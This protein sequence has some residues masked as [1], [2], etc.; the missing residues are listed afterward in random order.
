MKTIAILLQIACLFLIFGCGHEAERFAFQPKF[1]APAEEITVTYD[2]SGTLLDSTESI[3][4]LAYC[5]PEG[6]PYVEEV[7]MKKNGKNWKGAFQTADTTLVVYVIFRSDEFLDDNY[8]EGY[9]ITLSTP[10][11]KPIKGAMARHA[12]VVSEGGIGPLRLKRD[13]EKKLNYLEKEFELYPEQKEKEDLIFQYWSV[14]SYFQNELAP[15]LMRD[16]LE[17]LEREED[18]NLRDLSMLAYWYEELDDEVKAGKYEK[19]LLEMK[20]IE[21]MSE[22]ERYAECAREASIYKKL[23]LIQTFSSDFPDSEHISRLHYSVISEFIENKQFQEGLDYLHNYMLDPDPDVMN[24]LAWAMIRRD[25]MLDTAVNLSKEA[26]AIVRAQQELEKM[27]AH[28]T[29]R[30]W[31]ER[32]NLILSEYLDTYGLGLCKLGKIEESVFVF[33]EA[34]EKNQHKSAAIRERYSQ[35]LVELGEIEKA[36]DIMR[37]VVWDYPARQKARAFYTKLYEEQTGS[38]EGLESFFTKVE[39]HDRLRKEAEIRTQMI[40]KKAPQF[41]LRDLDGNKVSLADYKGK[42]VILDFW[43]T[44]CGMCLKSFPDMQRTVNKYKDDNQVKFLFVDTLEKIE[45]PENRVREIIDKNNYTFHILLDED[46][47]VAG[48][49]KITSAPYEVIIGP[50]G[51]ICFEIKGYGGEHVEKLDMM[52]AMLR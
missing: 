2:P 23:Q 43:G 22:Y 20:Q 35:A 26:V 3:K 50:K 51:N 8:K 15:R 31:Q 12:G 21:G 38:T 47:A 33:A 27:P 19:Q 41:T 6:M 28:Y 40:N 4:M 42:I 49:Y 52:I 11:R 36:N 13:F 48:A 24:D 32:Q 25:I 39:E 9:S 7:E 30:E 29:S 10:D 16:Y 37:S 17:K 1:P 46:N 44:W 14:S 34:V 18:K 45:D 5:Y